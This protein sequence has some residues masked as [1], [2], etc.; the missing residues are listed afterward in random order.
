[1]TLKYREI[2]QRNIYFLIEVILS[3]AGCLSTLKCVSDFVYHLKELQIEVNR[4]R[5]SGIKG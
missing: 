1:M 5:D 2:G 4:R 3:V